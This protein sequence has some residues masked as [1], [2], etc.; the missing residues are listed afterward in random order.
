MEENKDHPFHISLTLGDENEFVCLSNL[1][2]RD[3]I[4]NT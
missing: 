4:Q 2:M 1:Q 3:S